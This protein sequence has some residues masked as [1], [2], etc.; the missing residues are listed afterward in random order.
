MEITLGHYCVCSA[1]ILFF[2]DLEDHV[3]PVPVPAQMWLLNPETRHAHI[4][5][6]SPQNQRYEMVDNVPEGSW[7]HP[8]LH[9]W[10]WPPHVN[11]KKLLEPHIDRRP[12]PQPL[13]GVAEPMDV[14]ITPPG[15][16]A[17]R[18]GGI[19]PF[20]AAPPKQAPFTPPVQHGP[21]PSGQLED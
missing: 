9:H 20:N 5:A 8:T 2:V 12:G 18:A 19:P 17:Q 1:P 13:A 11:V 10:A 4:I 6:W 21:P 15:Q 16:V 7:Q 14:Q 3:Q